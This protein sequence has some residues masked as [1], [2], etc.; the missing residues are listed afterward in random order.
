MAAKDSTSDKSDS[1]YQVL[2]SPV[3]KNDPCAVPW[4]HRPHPFVTSNWL[5]QALLLWLDPLVLKGAKTPLT[6]DDVWQLAPADT[7]AHLQAR[8]Q[9]AWAVE[10]KTAS[11]SFL[12]ALVR[13]F[14]REIGIV[15]GLYT[16]SC[17]LILAQPI[18][19]KSLLQFLANPSSAASAVTDLGTSNGYKL[20]TLLT[21]MSFVSVTLMDLGMVFAG[22]LG[23]NA[24]AIVMDLVF[25]KTL[26]GEA[27]PTSSGDLATLA[28]VDSTG[29]FMC[30]LW[31]MWTALSPLMVLAIF[32]MIGF[33]LGAWPAVVGGVVMLALMAFGISE[34]RAV[35]AIQKDALVVQ[36]ERVKFTNQ[37]LHGVRTVKM[38]GWEAPLQAHVDAIRATELKL[39]KSYH[40]RRQVSSIVLLVAPIMSLALCL[41]VFVAQG[42]K[43]TPPL[44]FATLAFMNA[45]RTPCSSFSF[46]IMNLFGAINSCHRV[47]AFL[48]ADAVPSKPPSQTFS[49]DSNVVM[50]DAASFDVSAPSGHRVLNNISVVVPSTPS[51]MIV[52]GSVGS[53]KSSLLTAILGELVLVSG[54][55]SVT[56]RIAYASQDPWLQLTTVR[57]NIVFSTSA[58]KQAPVDEDRY[59]RV[60]SACQL[61]SDLAALPDRDLTEIGSRGVTLSGGQKARVGLARAAYKKADVYLLDDPLSALDVHVATNVFKDCIQALLSQSSPV[62]LVVNSHYH[63]LPLADRVLVMEN[64]SIVGDGK[65]ASLAMAFPHLVAF[66]TSSALNADAT[67][68]PSSA[69]LTMDSTS[70][71]AASAA[72]I[73]PEERNVGRVTT[74]TYT[75]YFSAS[76]W[77]GVG[78]AI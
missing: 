1:T 42:H 16:L 75:T 28:S 4:S 54:T 65:L 2:A 31:F 18:V 64:G 58:G 6:E 27:K 70:P 59:A 7:A 51:L 30:G 22:R 21:G 60:L 9:V 77:N 76:G 45:A 78:V 43:L 48:A 62:V 3:V 39:L 33:D 15:M 71:L 49:H 52:V 24:K 35:G 57:D 14:R 68:A 38:Y 53:G 32:V 46:S 74:Q 17:A 8:F 56:S 40:I 63:L 34:G 23:C 26:S 50:L 19:I 29:L 25:L 12:R 41:V 55:S 5:S 36:G 11:P 47:D 73:V 61:E 20:A 10:I 69:S 72:L 37:L 66:S 13:T 67:T 44:V